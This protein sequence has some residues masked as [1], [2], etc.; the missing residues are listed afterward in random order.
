MLRQLF[1]PLTLVLSFT[2][3]ARADD[4]KDAEAMQGTWLPTSAEIA[5]KM[6]PDQIRQAITLVVKEGKYKV[7]AGKVVDEG[8]IK[9]NSA[10][11]LK[12]MDITGTNGPIQGK[13]LLAIYELEGDTLR[14]CYDLTGKS[15]P[16]GFAT[17]DKPQ[18]YMVTYQ[19][20][21]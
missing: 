13:T 10:A 16:Q 7:T 6:L 3:A 2:L 18:L 21:K 14:I 9:L 12:E 8:T 19:R 20:K 15:Y 5:G 17:K 4:S 11:Q 1:I